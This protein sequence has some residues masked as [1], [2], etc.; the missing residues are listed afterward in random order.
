MS[1]LKTNTPLAPSVSL[2]YVIRY[3]ADLE[4]SVAFYRD[5]LGL[6]IEYQ[7]EGYVAFRIEGSVIFALLARER[8]PELL[9]TE[10]SS[11][12]PRDCHEGQVAFFTAKVDALH[13]ALLRKGV[14][15]LCAP[16]DR[17]WG[18]RTAYFKDPDGYLIEITQKL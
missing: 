9:G 12:P 1:H 18:E 5:T 13:A 3:A 10:E 15:F 16:T 6:E 2:G 7:A 14:K 11:A 17:P 4:R 8:V